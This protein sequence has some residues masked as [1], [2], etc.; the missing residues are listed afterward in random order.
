[1]IIASSHEKMKK[2]VLH[3]GTMS[4]T[5]LGPQQFLKLKLAFDFLAGVATAHFVLG[6]KL[7]CVIC[8]PLPN[9]SKKSIEFL[10]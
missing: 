4:C 9:F 1:L 3:V 7:L 6:C 10:A 5:N 2:I 8:E